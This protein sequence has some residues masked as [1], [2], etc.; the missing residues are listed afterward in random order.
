MTETE[1]AELLD[2]MGISWDDPR[3]DLAERYVRRSTE[4]RSLI[5]LFRVLELEEE[6]K[7]H[8]ARALTKER[9]VNGFVAFGITAAWFAQQALGTPELPWTD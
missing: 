2:E 7:A 8:T 9:L 4:A 6:F 1:L 3:R 5:I